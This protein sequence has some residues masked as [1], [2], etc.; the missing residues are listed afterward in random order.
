[1]TTASAGNAGKILVL[2]AEGKLDVDITG[3]VEWNNILNKP[4]STPTQI[5]QAVTAATHTNRATLDKFSESDGKLMFNGAEV[6]MASAVTALSSTV[7]QHTTQIAQLGLG[8]LTV[9]DDVTVDLADAAE[10]QLAL[11][12]I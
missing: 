2:N 11:E 8:C 5:D 6:A 12:L 7:S 3:H 9:V 10:G 1:M 4:T